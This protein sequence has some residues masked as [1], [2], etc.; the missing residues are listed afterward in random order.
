MG[1]WEKEECLFARARQGGGQG[2]AYDNSEQRRAAGRTECLSR[3]LP[4]SFFVFCCLFP[5]HHPF[6]LLL[7]LHQNSS[8]LP[9]PLPLHYHQSH[10]ITSLLGPSARSATRRASLFFTV[11]RGPLCRGKGRGGQNRGES[12]RWKADGWM[13]EASDWKREEEEL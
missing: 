2:R 12:R 3:D 4:F 9:L 8:S 13:G 10:H 6:L 5:S 7:L 1:K 11:L